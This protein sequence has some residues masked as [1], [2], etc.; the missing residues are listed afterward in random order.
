[1]VTLEIPEK[2]ARELAT[3]LTFFCSR[4]TSLRGAIVCIDGD[5]SFFPSTR[6]ALA[7]ALNQCTCPQGV[8]T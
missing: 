5:P 6:A 8:H 4:G 3:I 7:C 1:M 2:E